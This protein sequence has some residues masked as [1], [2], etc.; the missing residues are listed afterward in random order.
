MEADI[1]LIRGTPWTQRQICSREWPSSGFS[2]CVTMAMLQAPLLITPGPARPDLLPM[3]IAFSDYDRT[4]PLADGRV[5]PEGIAASYTFDDIAQ[6]CVRPV[7]EEFD[8]AE[9]SFSWYIMARDRGEPVIALPIFPLRMPV[10]AYVFC[11]QDAAF[12]SPAELAQK[13]IGLIRY[14]LTVNL[15]LRGIVNEHYGVAPEDS[16][17][18]TTGADEGAGFVPPSGI[19]LTVREGESVERLLLDGDIDCV[20][21]PDLLK[22]FR[23][24][25][26]QIRRIFPDARAELAAYYEKTNIMPITHVMV[27]SEKLLAREPWIAQSLYDAFAEAQRIVDEAYEQPKYVSMPDALF[28]I[29][30]QRRTFGGSLYSQGLRDNRHTVETFVRYGLEQGYIGRHLAADDLFAPV[31]PR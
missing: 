21:S 6:F 17:W 22:G 24:G 3:R 14:R 10:H 16:S 11:R 18:V 12:T 31:G 30:N 5:L 15:W 20:Y 23:D 27:V 19:D 4:R 28:A 2:E 7:Y 13:R 9:M 29:E 8:V 1:S 26:P 25:N